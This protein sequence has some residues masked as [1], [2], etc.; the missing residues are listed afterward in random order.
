MALF[1]QGIFQIARLKVAGV[2]CAAHRQ[3]IQIW[4]VVTGL[5]GV[6]VRRVQVKYGARV[7]EPAE[8]VS[9]S[10]RACK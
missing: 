3:R 8:E 6:R 10:S 2:Y 4:R 1:L 5:H 7:Y 9:S